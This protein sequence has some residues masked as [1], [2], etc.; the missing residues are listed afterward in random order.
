VGFA[1]TAAF[2]VT[3]SGNRFNGCY[4][5]GGRAIFTAPGRNIWTNGF[6]CCQRGDAVPNTTSSGITLVGTSIDPGLQIVNNEFGGGSIFHVEKLWPEFYEVEGDATHATMIENSRDCSTEF[7]ISA[8]NEECEGLSR[9]VAGSKSLVACASECC[10]DS[11]CSV[12]QFCPAGLNCEGATGN[13]AQCW[14]GKYTDC[15]SGT[16][17]GWQGMASSKQGIKVNGVRIAH[18]SFSKGGVGT[19]ATKAITQSNASVWEFDFCDQLV[20]PTIA[21]VRVDVITA[22][23]FPRAIARPPQGCKM[24]VETDTAMTGTIIVE[25]DSSSP[26]SS[27]V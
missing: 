10:S 9:S 24:T 12:Y 17:K 15:D 3:R 22:S 19:Q 21:T 5:D 25:V 13:D 20:F 18:N 26:T 14:L 2:H 7:N 6:E 27:F 4:I 16:R 8:A 11:S 23:G 1:N